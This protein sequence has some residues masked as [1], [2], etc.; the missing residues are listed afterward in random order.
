MKRINYTTGEV[1]EGP[2]LGKGHDV[3]VLSYKDFATLMEA[4]QEER[5]AWVARMLVFFP[6]VEV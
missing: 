2:V 3:V 4:G 5:K 6:R 1:L